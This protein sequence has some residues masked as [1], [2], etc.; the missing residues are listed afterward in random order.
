MTQTSKTRKRFPN[1]FKSYIETHY[2]VVNY[3]TEKML[4]DSKGEEGNG[5]RLFLLI[6]NSGIGAIMEL[7]E[8]ITDYF[9]RDNKGRIWDGEFFEEVEMYTSN[10][11]QHLS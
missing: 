10:Y 3:I 7:A 8:D 11:I 5:N 1:G 9:E 2:H 4:D 6:S